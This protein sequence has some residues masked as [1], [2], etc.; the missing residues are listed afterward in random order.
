MAGRDGSSAAVIHNYT[1]TNPKAR[2][3][4]SSEMT[5]VVAIDRTNVRPTSLGHRRSKPK[6]TFEPV[7]AAFGRSGQ[8]PRGSCVN[9]LAH[10]HQKQALQGELSEC[11][12]LTGMRSVLTP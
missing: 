10:G 6:P 5:I 3:A 7:S 12:Q 1:R 2:D 11:N 9:V 8:R 4:E